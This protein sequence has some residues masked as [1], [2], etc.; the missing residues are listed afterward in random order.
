M[1]RGETYEGDIQYVD[2][3]KAG[4][5]MLDIDMSA[6]REARKGNHQ[7]RAPGDKEH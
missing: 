7:L 4:P 6:N 1:W 2:D 3:T 5:N